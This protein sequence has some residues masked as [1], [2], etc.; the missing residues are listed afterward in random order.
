M[1]IIIQSVRVMKFKQWTVQ[2]DRLPRAT[3]N[4]F[5]IIIHGIKFVIQI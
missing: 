2:S 1:H 4:Y 3:L 5:H